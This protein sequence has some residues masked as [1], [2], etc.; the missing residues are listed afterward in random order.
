MISKLNPA[1]FS[2][3]YFVAVILLAHFS[4]PPGYRWTHNTISELASQ[5]HKNRGSMQAGFIGFGLLLNAG[6][7]LK[8]AAAGK[9]IYPDILIMIYGLAILLSGFFCTAPID[10]SI[11]YSPSEARWHSIFASVA[12][13][14][15][16]LGVLWYLGLS[17]QAG[18]RWFHLVF[19]VLTLGSSL[20]FGLAENRSIGIAKGVIQR[21]LYTTSFIWLVA[22]QSWP[23]P[24]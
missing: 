2:V 21:V 13:F 20:L 7:I 11:P 8:F 9:I 6:F 10:E 16:S 15:F 14:G 3:A 17:A 22:G 4:A 19:L 1:A 23:L 18:E 24:Q 12:G 5:G